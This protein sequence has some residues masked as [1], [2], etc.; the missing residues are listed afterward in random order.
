[1]LTAKEEEWRFRV[2][3]DVGEIL[4]EIEQAR[5]SA[6]THPEANLLLAVLENAISY[7]F[8]RGTG[9][10]NTRLVEEAREWIDSDS[11]GY[12]FDYIIICTVLGIPVNRL[13]KKL[14]E[15][16]EV[17]D[18]KNEEGRIRGRRQNFGQFIGGLR[19]RGAAMSS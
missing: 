16:R 11:D 9:I 1:M 8:L 7:Y 14:H 18:E 17:I 4:P 3:K 10:K 5:V 2:A 15:Y 12:I 6:S 19:I 13:R